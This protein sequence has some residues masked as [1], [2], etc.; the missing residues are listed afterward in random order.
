MTMQLIQVLQR[1]LCENKQNI[2]SRIDNREKCKSKNRQSKKAKTKEE[3]YE[4]RKKMMK[5]TRSTSPHIAPN[6]NQLEKALKI[7]GNEWEIFDRLPNAQESKTKQISKFK[8]PSQDLLN[9]L[10]GGKKQKVNLV[11]NFDRLMRRKW[12]D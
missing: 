5:R 6:D 4:I 12:R 10:A 7:K 1:C 3:L 11:V 2:M 8:E 9:R